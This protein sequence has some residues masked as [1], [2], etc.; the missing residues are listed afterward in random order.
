VRAEPNKRVDQDGSGRCRY[1]NE[2][3]PPRRSA[4][5]P[6]AASGAIA[7]DSKQ[8]TAARERRRRPGCGSGMGTT[9]RPRRDSF[10]AGEMAT[11]NHLGGVWCGVRLPWGRGA[12][13]AVRVRSAVAGSPSGVSRRGPPCL[14]RMY[15]PGASLSSSFRT[16]FLIRS[17]AIAGDGG[18]PV[19]TRRKTLQ[20]SCQP[21][22]KTGFRKKNARRLGS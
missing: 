3:F 10:A 17:A 7:R 4:R 16:D 20:R 12:A 2:P 18:P 9:S 19:A 22:R 21:V 1:I 14:E 15:Y 5:L 13:R 8:R 11:G 6:G